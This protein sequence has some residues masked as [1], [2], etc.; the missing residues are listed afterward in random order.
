MDF[1]FWFFW[2]VVGR[3]IARRSRSDLPVAITI[4]EAYFELLS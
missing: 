4:S 3:F 1:G 2:F